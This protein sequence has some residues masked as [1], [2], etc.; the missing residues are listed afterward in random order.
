MDDVTRTRVQL[1][2][3]TGQDFELVVIFAVAF[4]LFVWV[5]MLVHQERRWSRACFI[6]SL[7]RQVETDVLAAQAGFH[8]QYC[9]FGYAQVLGHRAHLLA[10]HP[11][12][13]LFGFAQVEK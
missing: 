3:S 10:I 1:R 12:Q 4:Q 13:T 5:F 6:F 7:G 8:F 11:T 2:Q 9:G